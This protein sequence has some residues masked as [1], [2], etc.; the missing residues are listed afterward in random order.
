MG[1]RLLE[2][3]FG[4]NELCGGRRGWGHRR[5]R[6]GQGTR[7]RG[8]LTVPG[9]CSNTGSAE[10]RFA[11]LLYS[12]DEILPCST[13]FALTI[14]SDIDG[15]RRVE[16]IDSYSKANNKLAR[17]VTLFT[18]PHRTALPRILSSFVHLFYSASLALPLA[19][20]CR[21]HSPREYPTL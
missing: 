2:V 6:A 14:E 12:D 1:A 18:T 7:D 9:D 3:K 5:T 16:H 21:V 19:P 10:E 4:R 8:Q 13:F 20:R 15:Q 17:R 11:A